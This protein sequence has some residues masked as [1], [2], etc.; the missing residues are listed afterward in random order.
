MF[1]HM[2]EGGFVVKRS[3][4]TFNCVPTDQA[5]EQSIN[6]EAKRQGGVIGYTLGKRSLSSLAADPPQKPGIR[7]TIKEMCTPTK[8]KNT[9]ELGHARVTKDQ[10]D[11]KVIKEYI[12][13]QCQDPFDLESVATSL[14][15]ITSGQVASEEVEESM[16]GV[17]Q[18]GRE[19]FNQFTRKAWGRKE[20]EFLGSNPQDSSQNVFLFM[21][22]CLSSDRKGR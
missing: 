16:K 21:R 2:S 18:K 6:R 3:E 12:K 15:N 9:H 10:N 5:L 17:P 14:V 13:E 22:K 19:M 4:R 7:R 11:V 8:S 1:Q 20:E